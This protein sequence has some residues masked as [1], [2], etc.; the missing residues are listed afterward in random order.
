MR[1]FLISISVLIAFFIGCSGS[2]PVQPVADPDQQFTASSDLSGTG[3]LLLGIFNIVVDPDAMTAE[4]TPLRTADFNLN[5]IKFLQPPATPIQ[6]LTVEFDLGTSDP[7]NGFFALNL[8]ITH[9]FPGLHQFRIFDV[10]GIFLS[11]GNDVGEYDSTVIMAGENESQLV[12]ADGYT[13]FWNWIEFTNYEM[14]LGACQSNMTPPIHCSSTVNG[15]KYFAEGLEAD[16]LIEDLDPEMRGIFYT[17]GIKER[18]YEIQFKM[19]G[20]SPVFDFNL[21]VDAAWDEPDHDFEPEYPVESFPL[22][23]NCA[24]AYHMIATDAGSD[25]YYVDE[26]INGGSF[27]FDM[28]IFDHQ[29]AV[30][31]DGVPGEIN[32]IWLEGDSLAVP[33]NILS[34]ATAM[35][36]NGYDSSTFHV[37]LA[38]LNLTQSGE[39]EF[40]CTIESENPQTY[41][42]QIEGGEFFHYPDAHLAAYFKFELPIKGDSPYIP[43]TVTQINPDEGCPDCS[44]EH[45]T[46]SGDDFIDGSVF[47]LEM[48]GQED[49]FAENV[50]FIDKN[51]LEGDLN[52]AGAMPGLWDVTVEVFAGISGTLEDGFT[53]EDAIYV[54]GD[55]A[56]DPDMDGTPDHPF[57]TIQLGLAKALVSNNEPV[58]VDQC[59]VPYDPFEVYQNSHIIGC[60]W[61]DGVGW[62]TVVQIDQH[63]YSY[64]IDNVTIEGM[65]FDITRNQMPGPIVTDHI[66]MQF[67]GGTG[68]K[69]TR[70]KFTGEVTNQGASWLIKLHAIVNLEISYCEFTEIY[71]RGTE[72]GYRGMFALSLT[73]VSGCHL[74]HCEFHNIGFD[75]H[76]SLTG[77]SKVTVISAGPISNNLDFHNLLIYDIYDKTDGIGMYGGNDIYPLTCPM[78]EGSYFNLYNITVDDIRHADPPESTTVEAG[79]ASGMYMFA[80]HTPRNWKNNIVSNIIATD[81]P[82][83]VGW[84]S[85]YGYYCE[86]IMTPPPS[87]QPMDYSAVY[88]V[89]RPL[90]DGAPN[91]D[92][93]Y[94]GW[95][96]QVCYGT[97]CIYNF[98]END[99]QYDLTPGGNFYHPTNPD[100]A[101]GADDGSEM[102]AF[103]GPEG[104]WI[105][106]S[107]LD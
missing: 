71:R 64:H 52:L 12:N 55:N 41:M 26:I 36:G 56:G 95:E 13:R 44:S 86:G 35:A 78:I 60:N 8:E 23:A 29:G 48:D 103:G 4:I 24:E 3:N 87:P 74:H 11:N 17:T 102:G 85:F 49:I 57:D 92:G 91:S 100:Y 53:V 75:I 33:V 39:S 67:V 72:D 59:E 97:G 14:I 62:P 105:P 18:R 28:E 77:K 6:L 7:P 51:T 101:Y 70:C 98:E 38:N 80:P 19:V 21:A 9:P 47:Y 76:D 2:S 1:Y 84:S 104:D 54:D 10:R 37:E 82:V 93:W 34:T 32:A 42:P 106:P 58:I 61:N 89:A 43:P 83:I 22:T 63:N 25:A 81:D 96:D 16:G 65:H 79:V 15:Y 90:P 73:Q 99:P 94:Y 50:M 27:I 45:V 5:I 107:Q 66:G 68:I 31:P 46:V 88:N 69:F 30:N 20:G 40:F